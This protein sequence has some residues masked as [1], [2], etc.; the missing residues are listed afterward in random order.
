M[1]DNLVT[2]TITDLEAKIQVPLAKWLRKDPERGKRGG[3][4]GESEKRGGNGPQGRCL[5]V[6]TTHHDSSMGV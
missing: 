4:Q 6:V 2:K 3:M 5:K 1:L